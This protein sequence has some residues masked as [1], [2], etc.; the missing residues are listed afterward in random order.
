V[1][2]IKEIEERTCR[3]FK[4]TNVPV[5]VLREFKDYCKNECGDSY[6]VGLIQ[7]LKRKKEY[8]QIIPLLSSILNELNELKK[9]KLKGA[10]KTFE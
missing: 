9:Q 5:P 1:E 4:M 7:L 8:E 2:I 3:N 6:S 10:F